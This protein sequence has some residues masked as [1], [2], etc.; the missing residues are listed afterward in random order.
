[1]NN[2]T[3]KMNA[4][5][6]ILQALREDIT[7]LALASYIAEA[8]EA[9]SDEDMPN[10]KILQCG[11]NS[12]YALSR[13]LCKPEQVKAVFEMRL[14]CLSGY[15]PDVSACCVCGNTEPDEPMLS[16]EGGGVHC[17]GCGVRG[18]GRS[19]PL[20]RDSLAALR[21]IVTSPAKRIFSFS[22]KGEAMGRLTDACESYM[23][24]HTGRGYGALDYYKS[25]I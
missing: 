4:D 1:M 20:C 14:M 2:I 12:L 3:M 13:G 7:S 19:I 9:V 22:L 18:G 25:I 23:L 6:L 16:I 8:L 10:P 5:E 21:H 17:R 24:H 15:E 11:L